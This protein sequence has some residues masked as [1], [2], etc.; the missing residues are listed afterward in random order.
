MAFGAVVFGAVFGGVF[1]YVVGRCA[2]AWC[3]MDETVAILSTVG[4]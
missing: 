1:G 4:K 3:G 2:S